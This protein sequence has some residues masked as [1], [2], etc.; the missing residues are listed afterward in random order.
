MSNTQRG[1]N[2]WPRSCPT[3]GLPVA[4]DEPDG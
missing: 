3:K 1:S 4:M 2:E